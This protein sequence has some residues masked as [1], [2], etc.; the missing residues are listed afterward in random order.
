LREA[1]AFVILIK[2]C[3]KLLKLKDLPAV[4][5]GQT[6]Q[7][8]MRIGGADNGGLAQPATAFGAFG[9]QQ[10]AFA[11][12]TA[13]HFA[14]GGNLKPLSHSLIRSNT[15]GTSHKTSTSKRGANIGRV[16]TGCKGKFKNYEAILHAALARFR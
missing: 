13:H 6:A 14:R 1:G 11:A 12:M 7:H 8:P 4:T 5:E 15:F 10:M 9:R 16:W 2:F 3:Q